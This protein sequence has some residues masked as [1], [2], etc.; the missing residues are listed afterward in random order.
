MQLCDAVVSDDDSVDKKR[1]VIEGSSAL[2]AVSTV[3]PCKPLSH[4]SDDETT[5]ESD[6][7]LFLDHIPTAASESVSSTFDFQP[8]DDTDT[9]IPE[10]SCNMQIME[11]DPVM[12][13]FL[14][15]A[16]LSDM[17]EGPLNYA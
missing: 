12:V 10:V 17:G 14:R 11:N 16:L 2:A 13:D 6:Q 5:I 7:I 9:I 1:L 8:A 15:E 4:S 3:D